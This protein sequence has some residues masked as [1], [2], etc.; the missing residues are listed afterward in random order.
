VSAEDPVAKHLDYC[1]DVHIR[2]WL[3]VP[4]LVA[5]STG[6]F[7]LIV[8]MRLLNLYLQPPKFKYSSLKELAKLL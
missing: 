8:D 2:Q 6:M 4:H 5:A 7:G 1:C 3:D